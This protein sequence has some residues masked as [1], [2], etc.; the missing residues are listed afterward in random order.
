MSYYLRQIREI[1][2]QRYLKSSQLL[3]KY[4]F[5]GDRYVYKLRNGPQSAPHKSRIGCRRT[6]F[7]VRYIVLHW[8]LLFSGFWDQTQNRQNVRR[9]QIPY[10]RRQIRSELFFHF[11]NYLSCFLFSQG[12]QIIYCYVRDVTSGVFLRLLSNQSLPF[13]KPYRLS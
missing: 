11:A 2:V 10:P 7:I 8:F 6:Y 13:I 3:Y 4:I 12:I 5:T 1:F 9:S